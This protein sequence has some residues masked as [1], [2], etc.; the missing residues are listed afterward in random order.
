MLVGAPLTESRPDMGALPPKGICITTLVLG[1]AQSDLAWNTPPHV[2]LDVPTALMVTIDA[3]T[4]KLARIDKDTLL[5]DRMPYSKIF[6]IMH[7][8][9]RVIKHQQVKL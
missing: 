6:N 3:I 2:E 8:P 5:N 4:F 1:V 7:L 9:I